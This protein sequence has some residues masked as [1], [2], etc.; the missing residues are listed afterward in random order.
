MLGVTTFT[1]AFDSASALSSCNKGAI[2]RL[3]G[4]TLR[5]A[6][7]AW[8][9]ES[10]ACL[11][12]TNIGTAATAWATDATTA[13]ATFGNIADWD[14]SAVSNMRSLFYYKATFNADISKWNVASVSNMLQVD[15]LCR[16]LQTPRLVWRSLI[17][18]SFS[19]ALSA[20][21][22]SALGPVL[23]CHACPHAV[24]LLHRRAIPMRW[25]GMGRLLP[26]FTLFWEDTHSTY[27]V[28]RN[29]TEDLSVFAVALHLDR[30][31]P[32][33]FSARTR[34]VDPACTALTVGAQ[35]HAARA[36]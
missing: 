14:V 15:P 18:G 1:S 10:S 20:H 5:A 6:Y 9:G 32:T 11:V 26:C 13:A 12:D 22:L 34:P 4:A 36:L 16:A 23:G 24:L 27:S 8:S 21:A 35:A 17:G 28:V 19:T 7:P 30:R 3:W 33:H 29:S 31:G 25:L 2:Y